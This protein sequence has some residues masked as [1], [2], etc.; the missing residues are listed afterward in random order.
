[1]TSSVCASWYGAPHFKMVGGRHIMMQNVNANERKRFSANALLLFPTRGRLARNH[2]TCNL[3]GFSAALAPKFLSLGRLGLFFI[4][5][6]DFLLKNM[7]TCIFTIA[8]CVI[9]LKTFR[10]IYIYIKNHIFTYAIHRNMCIYTVN[11]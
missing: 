1:M 4:P 3:L 8:F 5:F 9:L 6:I 11:L 10:N 2:P 7:Q